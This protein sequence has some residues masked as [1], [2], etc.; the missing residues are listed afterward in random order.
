V[1]QPRIAQGVLIEKVVEEL[2]VVIPGSSEA[3]RIAGDVAVTLSE[4]Q[5]GHV[6]DADSPAVVKLAELGVID[7][8]GLSRRGLIKVGAIGAGAGIAVLAMPGVAAASS[9]VFNA[10]GA[11]EVDDGPFL[12]YFDFTIEDPESFP[13]GSLRLTFNFTGFVNPAGGY[14]P[15]STNSAQGTARFVISQSDFTDSGL[16][17]VL[18]DGDTLNDIVQLTVNNQTYIVDGVVPVP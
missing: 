13:V 8:P 1:N 5:S 11:Y 14:Q 4:I 6:V 18:Q 3:L 17:Q 10:L 15:N 2:V 12:V 9:P 7:V 16:L